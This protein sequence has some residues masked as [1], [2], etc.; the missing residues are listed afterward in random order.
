MHHFLN[1]PSYIIQY[2]YT[3]IT[4]SLMQ[5]LRSHGETG[6]RVHENHNAFLN[7]RHEELDPRIWIRNG[8]VADAREVRKDAVEQTHSDEREGR[9]HGE[10]D[11][12]LATRRVPEVGT[13]DDRQAEE[14]DVDDDE[15]GDA[16][17]GVRLA[18]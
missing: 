6:K 14:E 1:A 15:Y 11:A 4:P 3:P 12:F 5:L 9:N 16:D 17:F 2:P 13:G 10:V 7:D 18:G 8:E